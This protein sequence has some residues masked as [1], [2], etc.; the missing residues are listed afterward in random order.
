MNTEQTEIISA[1]SWAPLVVG[2]VLAGGQSR[3]MGGGDKAL[4]ELGGRPLVAHAIERLTPQ[5]GTVI[6]NA[7]RDRTDFAGF[8]RP[9][10][11]DTIEGF[12]GPLA[13]V[14]AGMLWARDQAPN[15]RWVATVAADTPFFPDD[16]IARCVAGAGHM[17]DMIALARSGD[18]MHPVFGLWPIALADDLA[19]WLRTPENR[20]VLAWVERHQLV[21]ITFPGFKLAGEMLDP[22]FNVNTTDD[23]DVAQAIFAE[24][25]S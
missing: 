17:E 10:V 6:I 4:M 18:K 23:L 12:A 22:F 16:L 15:A 21:E 19:E 7:N 24:M 14:L 8:S 11:A 25:Q 2:V 5:A 3:R 20:K 13:G 9:V 1:D